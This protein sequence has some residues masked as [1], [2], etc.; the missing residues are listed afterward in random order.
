V[1]RL[2]IVGIGLNGGAVE[3]QSQRW[4]DDTLSKLPH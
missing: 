3:S 1:D 2:F 4:D